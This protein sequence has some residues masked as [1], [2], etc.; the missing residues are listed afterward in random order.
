LNEDYER[1]KLRFHLDT[2]LLYNQV[3]EFDM[4]EKQL[5]K[6]RDSTLSGRAFRR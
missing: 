3:Y 5:T 6:L 2:P 1:N 4:V